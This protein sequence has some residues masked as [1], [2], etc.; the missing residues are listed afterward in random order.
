[1]E[2]AENLANLVHEFQIR[3]GTEFWL[4]FH[5]TFL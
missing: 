2:V 5:K 4:V 3:A 1:V